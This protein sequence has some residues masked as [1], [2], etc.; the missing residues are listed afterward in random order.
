MDRDDLAGVQFSVG[1]DDYFPEQS[2]KRWISG[3]S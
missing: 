1:E 2:P 3:F